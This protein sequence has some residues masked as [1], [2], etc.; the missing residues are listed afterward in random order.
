MNKLYT[1]LRQGWRHKF[2]GQ[3]VN[4]LEGGWGQYSKTLKFEKGWGA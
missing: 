1:P 4:S 3:E 2:E